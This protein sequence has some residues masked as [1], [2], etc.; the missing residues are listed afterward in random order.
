MSW[1]LILAVAT[2]GAIQSGVGA[3]SQVFTSRERCMAAAEF[4][5]NDVKRRGN[6]VITAVCVEQGPI[7][8]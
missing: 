2:S 8:K 7:N 6:T 5:A 3:I 1:I 4:V